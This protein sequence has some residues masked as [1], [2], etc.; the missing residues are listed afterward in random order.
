A[1][2]QMGIRTV[3]DIRGNQPFASALERR[4]AEA[5]GLV[6]RR[7]PLSFKPLRDGSDERVLAAMQNEADYPL[8]VH[9]NIDR[10]RT[11]AVIAAF[12]VRVQGWSG[13]AAAAEARQFGLRR[14]FVGLNRYL[15][16]ATGSES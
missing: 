7:V 15:R 2:R 11:S 13:A 12:R 14:Y 5:H 1:L 3:L 6:Y 16:S 4:M 10:D 8:F 9:C